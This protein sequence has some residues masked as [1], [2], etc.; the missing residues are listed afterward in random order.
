MNCSFSCDKDKEVFNKVFQYNLRL[1]C[2][3][4]NEKINI[5]GNKICNAINTIRIVPN[6][7]DEYL[8]S[9]RLNGETSSTGIGF[10]DIYMKGFSNA[11]EYK[12]SQIKHTF[13]HELWHAIYAIMNRDKDGFDTNGNRRMWIGKCNGEDYFGAG[14]TIAE[15]RTGKRYGKLFEETMMDIKASISLSEFDTESQRTNPGVTAD[16]ILS[17]HIDKW[18][19]NDQSGYAIF[20]SITRLM[21]AACLNEPDINYHYWIQR[22]ESIDDMKTKRQNGSI[23]Y[24]N[25]FLYGMMYDPIYIMEEYDKYMGEGEYLNLLKTTDIVYEQG[26]ALDKTIDSN[27]VKNIMKNISQFAQLRTIDLKQ[28]GIFSDDEIR[29]LSSKYNRI[30][31]TMQKEYG[32]YFSQDEIRK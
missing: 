17:E 8:D 27:L 2:G 15:R 23:I 29:V 13:S 7:P 3:N 28:K 19:N 10:S 6:G 1:L 12:Y 32:A 18:S 31:N 11:P 26:L 5:N 14:G 22:G 9:K 25:D 24:V 16:T 21:I 4:N 20:S 30:W